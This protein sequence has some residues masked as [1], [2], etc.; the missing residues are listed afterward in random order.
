[1]LFVTGKLAEPALRRTL[2]GMAA[3]FAADVAVMKITVA[4]L[5]TTPWIARFLEVPPGTDLVLIP[6]LCEGDPGVIEAK[7]GIRT[8]KGPKDL[9]EIPQYFGHAAAAPDYGAYAIE[10]LA[11]IN[12]APRLTRAEIRRTAEAFRAAAADVIDLGCTPG[13]PFPELAN[14]VR[15]LRADG[16][17]VSIDSFEADEIRTAVA[18]GAELV[19]SI[20]GS[21]LAV[22]RD[23]AEAGARV[24]VIPD[25]GAGLDTL[26]RN[27]QQLERFR[28]YGVA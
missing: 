23:A 11:E 19:L 27:I 6:G 12:N 15:E 20:N 5:M 2:T 26:E 17:R 14:V 1:V 13:V 4:A 8:E 7:V 24:V 9:R 3:E 10:I 16:F 22:S 18:A 21:N 28:L 25:F